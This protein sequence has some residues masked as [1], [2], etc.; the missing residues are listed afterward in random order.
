MNSN[1]YKANLRK[2]FFSAMVTL[3]FVAY[4]SKTYYNLILEKNIMHEKY[5][6]HST[7]ELLPYST[8]F[9][10]NNKHE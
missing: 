9:A 10:K 4:L 1:I 8:I 7:K 6:L 2:L 3:M 5:M